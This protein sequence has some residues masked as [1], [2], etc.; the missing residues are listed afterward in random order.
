MSDGHEGN[1]VTEDGRRD[2]RR[3]LGAQASS[4]FR[5][6]A[7]GDAIITRPLTPYEGTSER[8]DRMLGLLREADA[9][10]TNL[11]VLVHDYEPSPAAN[12]G[13]T[14]MRAPPRVLD[15]LTEA[16][17]DLFSA[18]TNHTL[19]YGRGG[20]ERTL[21]ALRKRN[22]TFAGLGE[23]LYEARRPGYLETSAGRVGMVS[24]CTSYTA[25]SEAGE[26]TAA[27]AGRPGLNPLGVERIHR[28]SSDR[29]DELQRVSEAAGIETIKQDWLDRGLYFGH[30]WDDDSHFHFG[31]IKFKTTEDGEEGVDFV[32]DEDDVAALTEWVD[33][34]NSNA[35]Y[36]IATIHTHQGVG[37]RQTTT[38]T[39]SFLK[40]VAREC[41]EA[42]ADAVVCTGPHVLRGIEVHRHSPIFYSL[43]NFI[44]QNET[45]ARLPPESFERYGL[46]DPTKVSDVF[47]ARLY[48][49]GGESTGDLANDR[50]WE[51]VVPVCVFD[52]EDGLTAIEL[53]PCTLQ[54]SATRPQ[55]GTPVL[56]TA[57]EA[58]EIL[59][60][61][62]ELSKPFGTE[63]SVS[64]GVGV[65]ELN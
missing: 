47:D 8:F 11:E 35:D 63:I 3:S 14:Y 7:T 53:H 17:I 4:S 64:D 24:A 16:G 18:A 32:A 6:A 59:K 22:L 29:M 38:E 23:T 46:D 50:F 58:S 57:D 42:G 27:M 61:I 49:G 60:D 36:V 48:D 5:L 1:P 30:D 10:V 34:A 31:D 39:P 41:V 65:V 55:R 33:D 9:S 13:G 25:G 28:I 43:G 26:Q 51:T 2:A 15:D 56:A 37:G 40:R 44:V 21:E 12:S 62:T 45:V 52:A 54:Q 19:D 20:I